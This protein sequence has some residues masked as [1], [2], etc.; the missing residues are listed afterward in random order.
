MT[1][2]SC[3]AEIDATASWC[4]RCGVGLGGAISARGGAGSAQGPGAADPEATVMTPPPSRPSA[5]AAVGTPAP[6]PS[7]AGPVSPGDAGPPPALQPGSD[8]G[9]RYHIESVLGE[10]GM[11]TVFR[12]RD[13]ELD[14]TVAIKIIRPAFLAQP[15]VLQRFKQE[16]LLGSKVSHRH[17]LRI[18]D[19]GDVGGQKFISMAYVEGQD[20]HEILQRQGRLTIA[21]ALRFA[22]QIAEALDAAHREGV[23][24]R[25]LK[26]HNIMVDRGDE[27]RVS[28]FGL[29]KSLESA[30]GGMTRTGELLGTPRYMAPEQVEGGAIDHRADI[31]ALGLILY[32]MVTG[33]LPFHGESAIQEL[34]ARV[35]LEAPDPRALNA[36]VPGP[37][38]EI[39]ARCLARVPADRYQSAGEVLDA[40]AAVNPEAP[41]QPLPGSGPLDVTVMGGGGR[42]PRDA[43]SSAGPGAGRAASDAGGGAAPAVA[44]GGGRRRLVAA[45]LAVAVLAGGG[46]LLFRLLA[47]RAAPGETVGVK[48]DGAGPATPAPER[49]LAVLPFRVLGDDSLQ[50]LADGLEEALSSKLFQLNQL[51]VASTRDVVEAGPFDSIEKA[52]RALGANLI[53]EGTVQVAG[54]RLR[55]VA[56]LHDVRAGTRIWS[57]QFTGLTADLFTLED[58]VHAELV[59]ALALEASTDVLARSAVRPTDNVEAYDLYLRGRTALRAENDPAKLKE[60]LA[61]FERAVGKDPV[62]ALAYAGL[63]DASLRLYNDTKDRLWSDRALAA[64]QRARDLNEQLPEVHLALGAVYTATGRRPEAVAELKRALELAPGSDEAHRRLASAYRAL[65]RR[66]DAVTAARRATEINPYFWRNHNTLGS[67]CL[68]FNDVACAA[69]AFNRVVELEPDNPVGHEN[70]GAVY[71]RQG[72]WEDAA[73]AF[74]KALALQPHWLTYSNLGSVYFFMGR[75]PDAVG[76]FEQANA[77]N[78]NDSVTLGNLADALRWSGRAA[79]ARQT[80]EKATSLAFRELQVNPRDAATIATVALYY[81]KSADTRRADEFIARARKIDGADVTLIYQQA[82]IDTLAGR[83]DVALRHLEEALAG[84]Y[85]VREARQDPELA[86]LA[87]DPRFAAVIDRA[88]AGAGGTSPRP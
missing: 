79:A 87:K 71:N 13:R 12:A 20:L 6:V 66:D 84:G 34:L 45:A 9:T 25:D 72:R 33:D 30:A 27:V 2:P 5:P 88:S 39:I 68:H 35:R 3:H 36:E 55:V 22:R 28:D 51:R 50:Y 63:A 21:R 61:L 29:A 65:G 44:A 32:E 60:G 85:P 23:V 78:P 47:N 26:P 70:L 75:Y 59:Q 67:I 10:G 77:L 80:Y 43:S 15:G 1:C 82:V 11:G 58:Q 37:L 53:V 62:F 83:T 76:A 18:H 73:A 16:L 19:L 7:G 74:Q 56:N 46:L 40:L 48:T 17:I 81:A 57:Q 69:A 31:Y 41:A 14:R 64:A 24:H 52:G 49:Y 38:A 8:L 4:P 54:D 42:P 86:A